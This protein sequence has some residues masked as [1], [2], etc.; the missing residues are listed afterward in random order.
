MFVGDTGGDCN[1]LLQLARVTEC[2][3]PVVEGRSEA[4]SQRKGCSEG[5]TGPI[6]VPDGGAGEPQRVMRLGIVR[7][8]G[9]YALQC[10]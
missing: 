10:C 1:R 2:F 7:C 6:D 4:G 9:D 3:A 8:Q 5:F